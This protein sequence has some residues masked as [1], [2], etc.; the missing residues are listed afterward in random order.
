[1][2]KNLSW[3]EAMAVLK[4]HEKAELDVDYEATIATLAD[5]PVYELPTLGLK[6]EG[7]EAVHEFYRRTLPYFAKLDVYADMRV[8]ALSED[9]HTVAREAYPYVVVDGK[10]VQCNYS[11]LI[12]VED[13][14]IKS[15]RLYVDPVFGA[16]FADS[17]G[18]DFEKLPGVTVMPWLQH[19]RSEQALTTA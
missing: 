18:E 12:V 7:A 9:G 13:G 6:F 4:A 8:H 17:L 5:N 2:T 19:Q 15:E 3:E 10:K 1:M 11:A 16:Y 14:K